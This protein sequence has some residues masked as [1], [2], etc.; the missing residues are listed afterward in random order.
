MKVKRIALYGG[1]F[2][3]VHNG[4]MSVAHALL[5]LFA[6][7]EVV[8][9]PA[10]VAPHKRDQFVSPALKRY[11]ML[12][13]ATQAEA[14]MRV[15]TFELDAPERPYTVETLA[16][17]KERYGQEA[18]LFF[19]MGADSWTDIKTWREW[20][21]VLKLTNH[22]VMTRP[23]YELEAAHVTDEIRERMVD[24]RG[25]GAEEIARRVDESDAEKIYVTDAVQMA[26]SA[27]QVR[28]LV[29]LGLDKEWPALVPQPVAEFIEKYRLYRDKA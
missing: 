4:H 15:S 11:A 14:R 12:A 27:T 16:R 20:E 6:L 17:M 19:V 1:T 21:R 22:I 7:D 18:R 9:I 25:V 2:D 5:Q 26:V 24:I 3:P 28:K 23:G 8:F 13:L 29:R 10:H